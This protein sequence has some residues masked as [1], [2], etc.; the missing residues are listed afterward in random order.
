MKQLLKRIKSAWQ[1]IW[2]DKLHMAKIDENGVMN[3]IFVPPIK[4]KTQINYNLPQTPVD[5]D[6]KN[7]Y[8]QVSPMDIISF[9]HRIGP[10]YEIILPITPSPLKDIPDSLLQDLNPYKGQE[11]N[12]T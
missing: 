7:S 4:V 12:G 3:F 10:D 9:S 8:Y 2:D 1:Y 6:L 5:L 11:D